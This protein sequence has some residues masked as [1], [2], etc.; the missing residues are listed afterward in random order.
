MPGLESN[1]LSAGQIQE[2]R[3][4]FHIEKGVYELKDDQHHLIARV[5]MTKNRIF[6]LKINSDVLLPCFS[7]I[8]HDESWFWHF[9]FGHLNFDRLKTLHN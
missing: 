8:I 2:N 6:S 5:A 4:I 7:T 9:R 3:Y 1:L